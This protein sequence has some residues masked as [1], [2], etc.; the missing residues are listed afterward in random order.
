[1]PCLSRG[2]VVFHACVAIQYND[3]M[4]FS[5][6]TEW[7]EGDSV[8]LELVP[9]LP[10]WPLTLYQCTMSGCA[11]SHGPSS[12]ST[13]RPWDHLE[14]SHFVTFLKFGHPLMSVCGQFDSITENCIAGRLIHVCNRS[15]LYSQLLLTRQYYALIKASILETNREHNSQQ[16]LECHTK[17]RLEHKN[18][19]SKIGHSVRPIGRITKIGTIKD[20]RIPKLWKLVLKV[21]AK[22]VLAIVI[23]LRRK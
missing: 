9:P 21:H 23:A 19:C 14:S 20:F 17:P 1:M 8:V 11:F 22:G 18:S 6:S 15:W 7:I 10:E 2:C 13:L 5:V 3:I 16:F 12:L 4:N